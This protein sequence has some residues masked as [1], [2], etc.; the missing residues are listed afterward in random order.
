MADSAELLRARFGI[1]LPGVEVPPEV[2]P[3]LDRR[4]TRRYTEQSVPDS[5]LDALLAAAQSA[6]TKSDLQQYSVVVMRDRARIKQIADWIAT[7]DWIASAPVFLV[8]C[9]DMRRN[10]RLC[11]QHGMPHANNNLDTFLNTA[12]DCSL[13]MAQ[14]IAAAD[15]VGLG[16]CPISYVRSHIERTSR[17]CCHCHPAFIRSRALPSAGRY[18]VAPFRCACHRLWW[19]T[20]NATM[21]H[22]RTTKSA[23]TTNAAEHANPWRQ[24]ASRTTTSIR[25]ANVLAGAKTSRASFRCPSASA[26]RPTSEH[27]V[28]TL[29]EDHVHHAPLIDNQTPPRPR[30]VRP[31]HAAS[32]IVY[33]GDGD[34]VA[35]L[36]GMRGAKHRFMPNRLVFP[37]GA[38]DRED[39]DAPSTTPLAPQTEHLLR[40]SANA[41]LAH[42]LGIA[43]ARELHEETGLSLGTP[44]SS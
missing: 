3:L 2:A 8:W 12:V 11:E 26:S 36:M 4:V 35:M 32:L 33:R 15:A 34:D 44:P 16:T 40:K 14:F 43:A 18:S 31:R 23:P 5:L 28:S 39:L 38:V 42:G 6:P 17:R 7:M 24:A 41:R 37:G 25:R 1:D 21:K 19:Y 9:G 13:A 20:A 27:G 22:G 29:P 10:Q 30:A